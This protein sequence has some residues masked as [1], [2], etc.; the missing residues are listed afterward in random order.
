MKKHR[1][2]PDDEDNRE[3]LTA[4]WLLA[5]GF[6][7]TPTEAVYRLP[8]PDGLSLDLAYD[9][10][11]PCWRASYAWL[12]TIEPPLQTGCRRVKYTVEVVKLWEGL[13]GKAWVEEE[14]LEPVA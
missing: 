12:A 2:L 4:A 5:H 3:P 10:A 1:P 14:H 11:V 13:W 9:A 8:V 7:C 6:R